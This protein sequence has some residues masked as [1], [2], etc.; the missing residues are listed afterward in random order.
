MVY[1]ITQP[2]QQQSGIEAF[3]EIVVATEFQLR[4][5]LLHNPHEVEV[6]L[7]SSARVSGGSKCS[8]TLLF[9]LTYNSER[10]GA[11]RF[12]RDTSMQSKPS[13]IR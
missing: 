13:A 3:R 12:W 9:L 10:L 1:K 11:F 5:G 4:S 7:I 6:T 2:L 8:R